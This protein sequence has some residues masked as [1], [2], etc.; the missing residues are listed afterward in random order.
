[1][2]AAFIFFWLSLFI[3][4]FCY[5]GYGLLLFCI[6]QSRKI[7]SFSKKKSAG[8]INLPVTFIVPAY[9]EADIIESKLRNT[10]ALAYPSQHMEIIFITD[11]STD[12]TEKI[13]Q[14]YPSVKLMHLPVRKGKYAAICRAMKDVHTPVVIFSD[15]NAMLN[16]N[17]IQKIIAH[18]ADS[19]TGGVAGEKKIL[20]GCSV[21][22]VGDPEGLYWEYESFMK[23]QDADFYTVVG[24][25]GELFSIRTELFR[26]TENHPIL[27][28]FEISMQVCLQGYRIAYEPDA[29]AE[30]MPSVSLKEEEKRKV[31]IS[32]GAFQSIGYL[33]KKLN[34]FKHPILCF[35]YFFRRLLRWTVC[36]VMIPILFI[37]N[38]YIVIQASY[39]IFY[40]CFLAGQLL[41]YLLVFTGWYL[42][43]KGR[44][45]GLLS[46]PFYFIFM[47]Y[48]LVKGLITFLQ[49]H[50][51]V[52]WKKSIRETMSATVK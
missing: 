15:A 21:S 38:V 14:R 40:S 13:V 36:P 4:F 49:G 8:E 24:A 12:G 31:R 18:Y 6:N 50:H 2:Q 33:N 51:S 5:I 25:A 41:F 11:G 3:L 34:V 46:I 27:D 9:N 28:D 44:H 30:E 19:K 23:K 10:L 39:L 35:Q 43:Q 29:Y 48:C 22:A 1:M 20:H 52:L 17:A 37:C 16:K 32:A 47:N 7:F 45:T 42:V 26:D